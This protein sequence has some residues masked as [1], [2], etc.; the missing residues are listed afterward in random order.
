MIK[1]I[2]YFILIVFISSC[3][4]DPCLTKD[5]FLK[6]TDSFFESFNESADALDVQSKADYEKRYEAFV[7][8]CYKKY[9]E[10]LSIK[11]K[12]DFW[13]KSLNF[14]LDLYD[15][16]LES[17][18][19]EADEDPFKKYVKGEI[20]QLIKDS[21]TEYMNEIAELLGDELPKI[22]E[23]FLGDLEKLGQDLIK[24]FQD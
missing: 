22:L 3:T 10:E 9:Q 2:L 18:L 13:K 17:L 14:Y 15:G 11:E 20:E 1:H 4:Q 6:S 23:S 16:K 21:G 19:E 5:Q 12:Q 24:I 7:N 8:N